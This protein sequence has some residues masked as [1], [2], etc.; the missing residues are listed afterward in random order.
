MKKVL[1]V[2]LASTI[3]VTLCACGQKAPE[4]Q[5]GTAGTEKAQ[6]EKTG[7]AGLPM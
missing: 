7:A 1:S 5:T 3:A 6:A 2:L 4:P